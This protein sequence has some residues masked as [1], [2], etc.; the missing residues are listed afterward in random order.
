[1]A[2]H[3]EII[4]EGVV[5]GVGFR[6]FAYRKAY[7]YRLTGYVKNLPSESVLCVVEG[8]EGMINDFIEEMRVGPALSR[9]T[10]VNVNI[11]ETLV[12]YKNFRIEF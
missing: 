11:T 7:Q 10:N 4:V 12:G 9:V 5:Q 8:P 1:M 2:S 6:Y 3:A